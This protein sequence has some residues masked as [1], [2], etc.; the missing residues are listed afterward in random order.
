[1]SFLEQNP[2]IW[3]SQLLIFTRN[4]FLGIFKNLISSMIPLSFLKSQLLLYNMLKSSIKSILC[5]WIPKQVD[6]VHQ[7]YGPFSVFSLS[8]VLQT[9][10]AAFTVN[11]PNKK[12]A[13]ASNL[14]D[15]FLPRG[16]EL[17]PLLLR[18]SLSKTALTWFFIIDSFS[19][20]II[21]LS[22]MSWFFLLTTYIYRDFF[23]WI[24]LM[25]AELMMMP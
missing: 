15:T 10:E 22:V 12:K 6:F 16:F 3:G 2:V 21:E 1:M 24:M 13:C 11:N 9:V 20:E 19:T 25:S 5:Q 14:S 4:S 23:W 17:H 8:S 7:I 18:S